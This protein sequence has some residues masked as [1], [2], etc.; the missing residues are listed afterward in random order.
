MFQ[1]SLSC[2]DRAVARSRHVFHT[3]DHIRDIARASRGLH[4]HVHVVAANPG[5]T[6]ASSVGA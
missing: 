4:S 1:P 5:R 3:A 6:P 2:A